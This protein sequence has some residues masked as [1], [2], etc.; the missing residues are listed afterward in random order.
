MRAFLDGNALLSREQALSHHQCDLGKW[1][2]GE[3]KERFGG[4][5]E[6]LVIAQPHEQI[7][8]VIGQVVELKEQGADQAAEAAYAEVT[9]R[10]GEIVARLDEFGRS[11]GR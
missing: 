11:L 8:K 5:P 7:Y 3:G 4:H 2:D 9:R 10:S 1:Y 6:F